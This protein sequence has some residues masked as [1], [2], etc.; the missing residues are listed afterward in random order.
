MAKYVTRGEVPGY[1]AE[2]MY[3]T[4]HFNPDYDYDEGSGSIPTPVRGFDYGCSIYIDGEKACSMDFIN[5]MLG[6]IS[7]PWAYVPIGVEYTVVFDYCSYDNVIFPPPQTYT[8][9]MTGETREVTAVYTISNYTDLSKRDI[10]G[11]TLTGIESANSY[12]IERSSRASYRIPLIYGAAYKN[13]QPNPSAYTVPSTNTGNTQPYYNYK[14]SQITSPFIETDTN[15]QATSAVLLYA[16]TSEFVFTGITLS[17]GYSPCKYIKFSTNQI[18][19]NG[20]N[21]IIA[22][23]DASGTIM[24]TW[25]IWCPPSTLSTISYTN[26]NSKTYEFLN[27]NLGFVSNSSGSKYGTSPFY[28]WGR[29]DPFL[30]SGA[31]QGTFSSANT[32]SSMAQTIQNPTVFNIGSRTYS[33]SWWSNNSAAPIFYNYWDSEISSTGTSDKVTSK[34]VYD[35]CPPGFAVPCGNAFL[36]FTT[37]TWDSGYTFGGNYFP[38]MGYRGYN[39]GVISNAGTDGHFLTTASNASNYKYSLFINSTTVTPQGY[40]RYYTSYGYTIRP[41]KIS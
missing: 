32:A 30:R 22:I 36:G 15:T 31:T 2:G 24:W 18:P 11:G 27:C 10:T 40:S 17:D 26:S 34:T 5:S 6:A 14:G 41:V 33:Y 7:N 1:V 13:G 29:K 23:K 12:V 3:E 37:G 28:Q 9:T 35:P 39:N 19:T 16:D 8:A 21:A 38:A 4:V 25:H 20:G